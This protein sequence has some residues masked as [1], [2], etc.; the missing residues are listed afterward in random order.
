VV[1]EACTEQSEVSNHLELRNEKDPLRDWQ[2][3]IRNVCAPRGISRP[4]KALF[5]E[6][7]EPLPA[8]LLRSLRPPSVWRIGGPN[9]HFDT[10]EQVCTNS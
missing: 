6:G 2:F 4:Q 1:S 3:E 7:G 9:F 10:V 5:A 8:D